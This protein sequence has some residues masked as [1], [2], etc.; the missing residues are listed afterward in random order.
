MDVEFARKVNI[1]ELYK[2]YRGLLKHVEARDWNQG[3]WY[4][5]FGG[6]AVRDSSRFV[7][8]DDGINLWN[9]RNRYKVREIDATKENPEDWRELEISQAAYLLFF[10]TEDIGYINDQLNRIG[11]PCNWA[12]GIEEILRSIDNIANEVQR[13]LSSRV[14]ALADKLNEISLAAAEATREQPQ[15]W[16]W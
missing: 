1:P 13:V 2:A 10:G 16:P 14:D 12:P 9:G 3:D 6:W 15:E 5:C 8:T 7:V 11:N 4:Q